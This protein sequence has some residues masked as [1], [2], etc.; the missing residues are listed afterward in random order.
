MRTHH[1]PRPNGPAVRSERSRTIPRCRRSHRRPVETRRAAVLAIA[2]ATALLAA[3]FARPA[4]AQ[5]LL[6]NGRFDADI[7]PFAS[8][9]PT[10]VSHDPTTDVGSPRSPGSIKLVNDIGSSSNVL[11][12][13]FCL[14]DPIPAGGHYFEYWMRFAAGETANGSAHAQF[15]TYASDDCSGVAT[16]YFQGPSIGPVIGRGLWVHVREGDITAAAG[17]VPAG[18]RSMRIFVSV[19]RKNAGT[20]TANFDGLFFAPVGKPLCKGLVPTLGGSDTDDALFGTAGRDVIVAFAG[21]D[22][23]YAGDDDDVV[24]AGKGDDT[25]FGE[26][27]NDTLLGQGGDDELYGDA[28]KDLLRGGPGADTLAGG[29]N[30]DRCIGGAGGADVAFSSCE[31]IR[32]VP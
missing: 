6:P 3:P 18:T 23:V 1:L 29:A 32:S 28:G 26:G 27:G 30:K 14:R 9:N 7:A 21:D 13:S 5:N 16:Q 19:A 20:L 31:R 10:R 11:S 15:V 24:C 22:T 4:G 25:V 12:A 8:T 2:V 17:Q